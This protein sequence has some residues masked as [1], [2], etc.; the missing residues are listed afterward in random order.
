MQA[1]TKSGEPVIIEK[2]VTKVTKTTRYVNSNG[3]QVEK[4]SQ[5]HKQISI[6]ASTKRNHIPVPTATVALP[7]HSP[8]WSEDNSKYEIEV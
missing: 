7:N 4:T 1:R 8:H 3:G 5:K 2:T 6:E